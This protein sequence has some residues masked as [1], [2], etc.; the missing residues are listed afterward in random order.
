[1][2]E[3]QA[4]G[5]IQEQNKLLR[6]YHPVLSMHA[7]FFLALSNIILLTRI[8]ELYCSPKLFTFNISQVLKGY[9]LL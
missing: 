7:D 5:N 8:L 2:G 4:Y 1:M 9:P 6:M 3:K